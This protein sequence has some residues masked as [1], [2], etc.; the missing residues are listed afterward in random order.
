M[1][2]KLDTILVDWGLW[3]LG[4]KW[5][6][7]LIVLL[8]TTAA[9]VG[10]SFLNLNITLFSLLPT[11]S[12]KVDELKR[13]NEEF[14]SVENIILV[15]EGENPSALRSAVDA[16]INELS[17]VKYS[18]TIRSV[19]GRLD[20][21]INPDFLLLLQAGNNGGGNNNH[22]AEPLPS[23]P[24]ALVSAM[25]QELYKMLADQELTSLEKKQI[26]EGIAGLHKFL[27]AFYADNQREE[28][29]ALQETVNEILTPESYFINDAQSMALIFIQPQITVDDWASLPGAI[30]KIEA[31]VLPFEEI[32]NVSIG[33]TGVPVVVKDE[34]VTNRRGVLVPALFALVLILIILILNFRMSI[35]P[36]IAGFPLLLGI[37]W[38]A[39]AA[40][41]LYGRLNITTV[42]AMV[43]L[44]GFGLDFAIHYLTAFL[45]ER[46][47]GKTFQESIEAGIG[48]NG[49]GMV[50]GAFA[51][52]AAFLTF[53]LADSLLVRELVVIAGIG[54]LCELFSIIILLPLLLSFRDSWIRKYSRKDS[55]VR[56]RSEVSVIGAMGGMVSKIP[57]T[58]LGTL[59][60]MT[61]FLSIYSPKVRFESNMMKLEADGLESVILQD[62]MVRE[63]GRSP[64]N[65][66]IYSG[67]LSETRVLVKQLE[68]AD[69]IK[70]VDS[71]VSFLPDSKQQNDLKVRLGQMLATDN[72]AEGLG[73]PE[74]QNQ[75]QLQQLQLEV[76]IV[77]DNL[78]LLARRAGYPGQVDLIDK[79]NGIFTETQT[80][81]RIYQDLIEFMIGFINR[82]IEA[83]LLT[84]DNLP[85]ELKNIY[86][87]SDETANLITLIPKENL[88]V[89]ENREALYAQLVPITD[90]FTGI[91]IV[92]DQLN[93]LVPKRGARATVI[94]ALVVFLILLVN[95]RNVKLAIITILPLLASFSALLGVMF[96]LGIKLDFVNIVAVPL[97][98]GVGINNAVH[99]NQRYMLEGKGNMEEVV[100]KIGRAFL[101]TTLLTCIG[102]VSY[103]PSSMHAVRSVGILLPISMV[104]A[105]GFSLFMH[106]SL[107]VIVRERLGLSLDP[108]KMGTGG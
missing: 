45:Q 33:L 94:A 36:I 86:F 15:L 49:R 27:D 59:F 68:K 3:A 8:I 60:V 81:M 93:H 21:A 69:L 13:I 98:L 107:L 63:F 22:Q 97:L 95:F 54:I 84:L 65:L 104:L 106:A 101:V 28:V 17:A 32:F 83:D 37:F 80:I 79:L 9:A 105:L 2:F 40:G 108:W 72:G 77:L 11:A 82:Q 5:K 53:A 25:N 24:V 31:A 41:A 50:I 35:V 30:G 87:N 70:E 99:I 62:R 66:Y 61:I 92:A 88:W 58:F 96:L 78:R 38:T 56:K 91:V 90:K 71:V 102:F 67:S 26:N 85:S 64:D 89:N 18:E 43:V 100:Q 20:T 55:I 73:N 44:L 34:V 14:P 10:C 12:E 75:K 48:K 52:S 51:T 1:S 47:T 23:E 76:G 16:V 4:H 46:E 29:Q 74:N 7:L 103:I 19:R 57:L 42:M 39:G 6:T